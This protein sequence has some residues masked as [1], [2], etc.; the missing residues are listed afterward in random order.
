MSKVIAKVSLLQE[1]DISEITI[2][3]NKPTTNVG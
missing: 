3:T 2:N 1:G